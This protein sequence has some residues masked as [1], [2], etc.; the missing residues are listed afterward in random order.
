MK[1]IFSATTFVALISA[2]AAAAPFKVTERSATGPLIFSKAADFIHVTSEADPNTDQAAAYGSLTG[3]IARTN[4]QDEFAS[5]VSFVIPALSSISGATTSS[6]CDFVIRNPANATGSQMTQLY[7]LGYQLPDSITFNSHP[8]HD[9]YEGVYQVVVGSDSIAVDVA[10]VPCQFGELMQF[11]MRPQNDNDY[12]T[13][14]QDTDVG[15]FIE[16]RN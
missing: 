13:W 10:T 5:Y 4:G 6:T 11:V 16:I 3:L 14:Q 8:Y 2:L 9:Q 12:I 1:G 15:A 7:T